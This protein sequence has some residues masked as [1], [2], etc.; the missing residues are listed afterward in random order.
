MQK[1]KKEGRNEILRQF[2]L[3]HQTLCITAINFENRS[4]IG[5]VELTLHPLKADLYCIKINSK[6]CKLYSICINDQWDVIF[7]YNDPTLEICQGDSKQ[8][9]LDFFS[10]LS[11]GISSLNRS[12]SWMWRSFA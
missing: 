11:Y 4:L 1:S 7:T 5:Y 3:S 8:R 10:T 2:R 6:Q 12:G 9:N